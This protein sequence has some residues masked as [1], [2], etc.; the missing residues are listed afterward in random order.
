VQKFL[1]SFSYLLYV[2]GKQHN[3]YQLTI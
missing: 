1:V 3:L 2:H